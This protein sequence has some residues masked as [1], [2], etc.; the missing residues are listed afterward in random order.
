MKKKRFIKLVMSRGFSRNEAREYVRSV[1]YINKGF[2][3]YN[4]VQK[5]NGHPYRL[6]LEAYSR[7]YEGMFI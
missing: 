5:A 4:K 6:R 3:R 1:A 2:S 7:E